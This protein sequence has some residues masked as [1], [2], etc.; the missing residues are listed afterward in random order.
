MQR[1]KNVTKTGVVGSAQRRREHSQLQ[2]HLNT[3]AKGEKKT[4]P[5]NKRQ[6]SNL[7]GG[8]L[9]KIIG[10]M[11]QRLAETNILAVCNT[12]H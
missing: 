3:D 1:R 4:R 8:E 9:P 11:K 2:I 10:L 5:A 7:S 6:K 12:G